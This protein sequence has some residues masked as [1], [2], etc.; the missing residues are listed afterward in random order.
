MSFNVD[1]QKQCQE[2]PVPLT[3]SFTR[4][5]VLSLFNRCSFCQ[6]CNQLSFTTSLASIKASFPFVEMNSFI[7][8]N[9]HLICWNIG[10]RFILF[11]LFK[12]ILQ[13]SDSVFQDDVF[14]INCNQILIRDTVRFHGTWLVHHLFLSRK[15]RAAQN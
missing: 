1:L 14:L 8:L 7:F 15:R 13:S 10:L 6:I 11:Y 4:Y 2:F 3:N 5:I 9:H 12:L